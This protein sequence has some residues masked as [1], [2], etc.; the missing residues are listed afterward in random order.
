MTHSNQQQQFFYLLKNIDYSQS[1]EQIDYGLGYDLGDHVLGDNNQQDGEIK[2][3]VRSTAK[4]LWAS[5]NGRFTKDGDY[6][7]NK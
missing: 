1:W 5:L 4:I 7:S 3:F 2:E 6:R